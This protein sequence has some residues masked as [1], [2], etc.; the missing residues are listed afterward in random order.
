[1]MRQDVWRE[2]LFG[3]LIVECC[4]VALRAMLNYKVLN[5]IN[6]II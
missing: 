6:H 3:M 4:M 2:E 5:F 1:M